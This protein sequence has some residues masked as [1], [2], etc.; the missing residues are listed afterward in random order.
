MRRLAGPSL[1][2]VEN[3]QNWGRSGAQEMITL[4]RSPDFSEAQSAH[5]CLEAASLTSVCE[6]LVS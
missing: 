1:L 5:L 6:G 4:G 2:E 3:K